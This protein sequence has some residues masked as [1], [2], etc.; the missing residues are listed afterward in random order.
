MDRRQFLAAGFAVS[1]LAIAGCGSD[2]DSGGTDAG[3]DGTATPTSGGQSDSG[4]GGTDTGT[5]TSAPVD[6]ST[7]GHTETAAD[8]PT[9]SPTETPTDSPTPTNSPTPTAT[10]SPT[11]TATPVPAQSFSGSGQEVR[12][13]V[14]IIGGLTV[15]EASYSGSGNFVVTLVPE[16]GEFDTIAV[17]SIGSYDGATAQLVSAGSYQLDVDAES[18]WDVSIRQPRPNSGESVPVSLDG[19]GPGVYGPFEFPDGPYTAAGSH[20]GQS[21]YIVEVVPLEGIAPTVVFNEIGR[22]EGETTFRPPA[23]G[24]VSVTAD[25]SWTLEME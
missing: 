23:L 4:S 6:T 17:N 10:P 20:D 13:G 14:S 3:G 22:F 5:P 25:G 7:T 11:P 15:V 24:Y 8:T 18:D 16:E 9:A 21:N 19:D 1:S 12:D 2:D